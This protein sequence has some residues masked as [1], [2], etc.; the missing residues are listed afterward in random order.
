MG[1]N[2]LL[3]KLSSISHKVSFSE[4][5]NTVLRGPPSKKRKT[6]DNKV[7]A[8]IDISA[9]IASACHGNGAELIDERH[10]TN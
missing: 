9:W 8:A 10:F 2:N 5:N 7:R 6:D 1:I 3:P 4:L